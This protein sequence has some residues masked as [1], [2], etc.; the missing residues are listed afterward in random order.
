[1]K[2]AGLALALL[3]CLA[4]CGGSSDNAPPPNR[5][6]ARMLAVDLECTGDDGNNPNK[7]SC[8]FDGSFLGI[9]TY[10]SKADLKADA[11][12]AATLDAHTLVNERELWM[13]DAPDA[14]T[15]EAAKAIVGG[16]IQ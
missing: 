4:G 16:K 1:M 11:K 14:A 8:E 7:V 12:S 3:L 5:V 10:E 15:L 2:F 6:T 9:T 13:I